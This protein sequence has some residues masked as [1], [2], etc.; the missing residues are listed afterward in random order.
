MRKQYAAWE[1]KIAALL[2]PKRWQ[3]TVGALEVALHLAKLHRVDEEKVY[4]AT[5][6]HDIGKAYPLEKQRE[7]AY[8][9]NLLTPE[10]SKAEGVIHARVSA[11]IARTQYGIE[12]EEILFVI[13]HHST[14]HPDYGPLGWILYVSDYL[15]PNRQLVHQQTLLASCE[16]N[17][18]EGC[19]LVLL[20]KLQYLF[21]ERRYLHTKSVEFYNSLL[22]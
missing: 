12:D 11:F 5:L 19:L 2:P 17:L 13:N 22:G 1:E 10:D 16:A 8:E 18:K 15:D 14:G 9:Q 3:H 20:A 6:L 4:L 21:D 7:I